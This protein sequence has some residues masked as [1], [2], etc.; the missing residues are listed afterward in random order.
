M[1]LILMYNT[2][3]YIGASFANDKNKN[4]GTA[5]LFS[6]L[7]HE[8]PHELG[9]FSIL[10]E[11]GL[12]KYEAI[13]AQFITGTMHIFMYI[14]IHICIYIYTYMYIYLFCIG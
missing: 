9:D 10:L 6:I 5:A 3:T 14:Y 12:S 1:Y 11:S 13:K 8:I 2:Y 4:L 7:F